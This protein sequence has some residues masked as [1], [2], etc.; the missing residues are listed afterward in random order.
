MYTDTLIRACTIV[1]SVQE[2]A[3]QD[4]VERRREERKAVGEENKA[5]GEDPSGAR[6]LTD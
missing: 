2:R 1:R 5:V 6:R 4:N 3:L